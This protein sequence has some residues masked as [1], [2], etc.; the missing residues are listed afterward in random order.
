MDNFLR[1]LASWKDIVVEPGSE[2]RFEFL[3]FPRGGMGLLVILGIL[4]ALVAVIAIYRRDGRNLSRGQRF[5]LGSLRLMAIALAAM[6]LLE[7]SLVAIK[8]DTRPGRTILLL[9][10][11]QSMS[12]VDAFRRD[13]V[14]DLAEAWRGLDVEDP[15][16]VDR[17]ALAKAILG[18]EDQIL[19]ERLG[20]ENELK[21]YGFSA[22]IEPLPVIGGGTT[23][24]GSDAA[25]A[26]D[27]DGA[28]DDGSSAAS[29]SSAGTSASAAESGSEIPPPPVLDLDRIEATGRYSNLGGAVRAALDR[30]RGSEVAGLV[31]LTDGR[32]NAG[33]Q[34]AE[35][36]RIIGQRKVPTTLVL[37]IGDP[38]ETQ[39][40][41][42]T[43]VEAPEKVFQK[44]PFELSAHIA[45]QGYEAT[46]VN[47]RLERVDDN[48]VV[49]PIVTQQ[50]TVGGEISEAVALFPGI[51]S[52]ESGA[53]IYRVEVD[54][55]IGEPAVPE[56]HRKGRRIEV[57]GEQTRVLL[58]SSCANF[59][60]RILRNQLIRDQSIEVTCWLQSADEDFPQDGDEDVRIKQLPSEQ[61]EL[62]PYD[63][64][65]FL[66]PNPE[67]LNKPWC[68]MVAKHILENGCGLWWICGER[69]SLKA[70]ADESS[71]SPL[72]ELLPVVPDVRKAGL[73]F[74]LGIGFPRELPYQLTPEGADGLGAKITRIAESKDESRLLWGRLPGFHVSFP[75]SRLKPAATALVV[76]TNREFNMED[77]S[78]Q[79]VIATQFVGAARVLFS[80][81]DEI[82]RWRSINEN[83]YDRLWLKG[84][85]FL[86]EG[87]LNAGNSKFKLLL[88]QERAELGE[89]IRIRAEAK[90]DSFNPLI[91]DAIEVVI[92]LDDRDIETIELLPVEEAPGQ[93]EVV[94]RPTEVGFFQVVNTQ[95]KDATATFQVVPAAIEKEGP[96]DLGELASLADVEGGRLLRTPQELLEAA[97][98]IPSRT[99]T[100]TYRTPH[101]L[102]DSWI[103]LALI[104]GLL[105]LEWWLRKRFNLL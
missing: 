75:V 80:G 27:G 64:V 5:V 34:G 21:V 3:S 25:A 77:G 29:E 12:H 50:V 68:D 97:S 30:S 38:S 82:Y 56:R 43:R 32:R 2:L 22:G 40:M 42:V 52:D 11:S 26:A 35:I 98:K 36:A 73:I 102:W 79:P 55:P 76:N 57:L 84:I 33:P 54:P 90:D 46:A 100:D 81:V 87:R 37:G 67:K 59:E 58:L 101:A 91:T 41:S 66:D 103:T 23:A 86:Y 14:A 4:A 10:L 69:Y 24:D 1:W 78:P 89:S 51:K 85:R 104:V 92:A 60:Y 96:V 20:K 93:Y 6:L 16:G 48:G 72:V 49:Q 88:S 47:V 53:W 28:V 18:R 83:A 9:D 61:A 63:V 94:Y 13:D 99:T 62:E 15:A 7:P 65:I 31:I 17:M 71:L 74:E 39:T 105:S 44:D 70:L 45:S 95:H 8:K 19:L